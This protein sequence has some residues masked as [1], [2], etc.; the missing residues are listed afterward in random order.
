MDDNAYID[1]ML[2]QADQNGYFADQVEYAM[3][4][5]NK[6]ILVRAVT[7]IAQKMFGPQIT[8]WVNDLIAWVVE[9]IWQRIRRRYW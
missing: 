5:Q 3:V 1:D 8:Q 7:W 9:K 4:T 6:G 2:Q